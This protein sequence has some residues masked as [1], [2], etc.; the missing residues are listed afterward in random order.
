MYGGPGGDAR[1]GVGGEGG[2]AHLDVV[3][4]TADLTCTAFRGLNY[5]SSSDSTL[6][7]KVVWRADE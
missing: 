2:G 4:P 5:A 3:F 6:L 7:C 1:S